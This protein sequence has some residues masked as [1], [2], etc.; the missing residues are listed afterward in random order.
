MALTDLQYLL[1]IVVLTSATVTYVIAWWRDLS[2]TW[3]WYIVGLIPVLSWALALMWGRP[4]PAP[5]AP[6]V[7]RHELERAA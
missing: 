6:A 5:P 4:F 3:A 2:Y 7:E 1:G